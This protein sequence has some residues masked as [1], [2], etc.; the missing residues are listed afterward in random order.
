M[1]IIWSALYFPVS[2]YGYIR[3]GIGLPKMIALYIRNFVLWGEHFYSWPLWYLLALI[4]SAAAFGWL[5]RRRW[6]ENRI[7]ILSLVVFMIAMGMT[8]LSGCSDPLP[9]PLKIVRRMILLTTGTGRIFTG[10]VYVSSGVVIAEKADKLLALKRRNIWL[11]LFLF[12]FLVSIFLPKWARDI[13]KLPLSISFFLEILSFS[14]HPKPIYKK[15]R[16]MSMILYF[17]HMYVFFAYCV[18]GKKIDAYGFQAFIITVICSMCI[19][20]IWIA[21]KNI[22]RKG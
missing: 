15:M 21:I 11:I 12:L 2:I 6:S 10:F 4:Y 8:I 18:I 17:I 19:S 7:I 3:E 9:T 13:I 20:C 1:Y 22:K 5:K 16:E 14:I